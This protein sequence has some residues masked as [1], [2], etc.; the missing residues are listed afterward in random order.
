MLAIALAPSFEVLGDECVLGTE[1]L[2]ERF[3]GDTG[4]MG[5]LLD[6]DSVNT[7]VAEQLSRH[8]EHSLGVRGQ[9][10]V[11][12]HASTVYRRLT[13]TFGCTVSRTGRVDIDPSVKTGAAV[14][15]QRTPT[16]PTPPHPLTRSGHLPWTRP[17]PTTPRVPCRRTSPPR[18]R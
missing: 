15:T 2:V 13:P 12:T 6:P 11:V 8:F 17:T 5:E 7:V 3:L 9:Y 4:L 18:K 14:A 16:S 1:P 10:G